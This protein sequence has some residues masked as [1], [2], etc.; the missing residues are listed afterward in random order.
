MVQ[1]AVASVV[2]WIVAEESGSQCPEMKSRIRA[3]LPKNF[4]A[5]CKDPIAIAEIS[6]YKI[7]TSS[8]VLFHNVTSTTKYHQNGN[9]PLPRRSNTSRS[10]PQTQKRHPHTRPRRQT[11][12][13]NHSPCHHHRQPPH[14]QQEIRALARKCPWPLPALRWRP[15]GRANTPLFRGY[16]PLHLD[17]TYAVRFAGPAEF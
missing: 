17:A 13:S 16:L 11:H 3:S 9:T 5:K 2:M 8:L 7:S 10:T 12:T 6:P 15:R 4:P 14:R 1:S